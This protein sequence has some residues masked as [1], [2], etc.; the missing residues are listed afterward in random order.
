[1]RRREF[2]TLIGGA[3]T[4]WPFAAHAQQAAMPVIGLLGSASA[5]DWKLNV[6]AFRQ[7][8]RDAGYVEGSNVAIEPR[9]ADSQ[10]QRLPAMAAELVQRKVTVIAAFSTPAARAAKTAT[11]VI[12]V[13]FT[14][15]RD[16]VEIGLV[17]S[18]SHPGGNMTGATNLGVELESKLLGLLHDAVPSAKIIA[19]LVNPTNFNTET[20][21]RSLQPAAR[22]LG[23]QLHVLNASTEGDFDTVFDALRQLRA[24]GLVVIEDVFFTTRSKQ[25]AALTIRHA[26]PAIFQNR[27]F[28]VAGGLMSYIGSVSDEYHQA[29]VYTG[30][31][32][33]GEKPADLP[34]VQGTRFELVIN[35]KTAK[36]LGLN[37][38]LGL[39]NVADEVIE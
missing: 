5:S 22:T 31:I 17:A 7:G 26:I 20:L 10:Y 15:N 21:S 29:G 37:V 3:A 13:V 11:T 12:P 2:I 38:P 8:L 19:V 25:L 18:L 39:L 33:K 23:L 32:L 4:P 16:P 30:R 1:M 9:W 34:V 28:A 14:T 36:A 6:N 24:D 27:E 35:L